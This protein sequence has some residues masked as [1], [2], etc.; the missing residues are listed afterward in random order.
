MNS[1]KSSGNRALLPHP[2][3]SKLFEKLDRDCRFG[4]K[5]FLNGTQNGEV[6]GNLFRAFLKTTDFFYL[7]EFR[8]DNLIGVGR[9]TFNA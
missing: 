7:G 4:G 6:A 9:N 3:S 8:E 1:A 2:L 5:A